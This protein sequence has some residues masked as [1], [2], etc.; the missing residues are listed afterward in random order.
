MHPASPAT[1]LLGAI[2]AATAGHSP[3]QEPGQRA[4]VAHRWSVPASPAVSPASE[5]TP[6]PA[7]L[8]PTAARAP[9]DRPVNADL[10]DARPSL[11][12]LNAEVARFAQ[13]LAEH[14]HDVV[15]IGNLVAATAAIDDWPTPLEDA[16]QVAVDILTLGQ[17]RRAGVQVGAQISITFM[18]TQGPPTSVH[19]PTSSACRFRLRGRDHDCPLRSQ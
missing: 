10:I 11:L 7:H 6:R 15:R 13:R 3:A 16:G 1:L 2:M 5:G 17:G 18:A 12:A 4:A 14:R 8:P 9:T 19:W